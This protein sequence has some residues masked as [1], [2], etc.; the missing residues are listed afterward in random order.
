MGFFT[1]C[2]AVTLVVLQS[3]AILLQRSQSTWGFRLMQLSAASSSSGLG[4][5]TLTILFNNNNNNN[6][7]QRRT[8]ITTGDASSSVSEDPSALAPFNPHLIVLALCCLQCLF[9][10]ARVNFSQ[11]AHPLSTGG[12]GV[13]LSVVLIA[14][15][16]VQGVH[17]STD[18]TN[19]T[20]MI[21]IAWLWLC[22]VYLVA[23]GDAWSHAYLFF[24]YTATVATPLASLA[25]ALYGTRMWADALSHWVLLDVASAA[26]WMQLV[27]T[28]VPQKQLLRVITLLFTLL[29]TLTA[30]TATGPYDQWR[31]VAIFAGSLGLL[32]LLAASTLLP[33]VE[34][35]NNNSKPPYR[36]WAGYVLIANNAA[37][38]SIVAT[39]A[40]F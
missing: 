39:L 26:G 20:T 35:D 27:L 17:N 29:P 6:N 28:D 3:T 34:E 25:A 24:A 8:L 21:F 40:N 23:A 37:L 1:L 14:A 12:T 7:N 9:A 30:M 5:A 16:V 18:L 36:T 15:A 19:Y 13:A 31:Y 2:V 33:P 4:N 10:M 38:M 22:G 11:E 32:P